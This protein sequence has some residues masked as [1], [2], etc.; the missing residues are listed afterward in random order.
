MKKILIMV[1]QGA[2]SP[3]EALGELASLARN[4]TFNRQKKDVLQI[5][6]WLSEKDL[7]VNEAE[8]ELKKWILDTI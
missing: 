1:W 3:T 6:T 7:N 8:K 4:G 5:L 2:L